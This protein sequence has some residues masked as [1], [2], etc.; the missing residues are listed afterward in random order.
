MY[1]KDIRGHD[2][3]LKF[4]EVEIELAN[5]IIIFTINNRISPEI[6]SKSIYFVKVLVKL[7]PNRHQLI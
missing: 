2:V 7:S 3:L 5:T 6:R 4:M 1:S